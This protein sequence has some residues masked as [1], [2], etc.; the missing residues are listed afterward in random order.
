MS[1]M[2]TPDGTKQPA[3][4]AAEAAREP[5]PPPSIKQPQPDAPKPGGNN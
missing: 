5:P 1:S 3:A 2:P 4:A